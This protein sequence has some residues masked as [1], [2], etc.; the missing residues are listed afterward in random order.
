MDGILAVGVEILY[1]ASLNFTGSKVNVSVIRSMFVR[2]VDFMSDSA[3]IRQ[4][5][6]CAGVIGFQA[7][8]KLNS[9]TRSIRWC[10]NKV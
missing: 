1:H 8:G 10:Y 9:S 7:S 4:T 6:H 2:T 5:Q 3:V